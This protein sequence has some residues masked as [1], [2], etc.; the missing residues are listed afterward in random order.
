MPVTVPTQTEFDALKQQVD[1]LDPTNQEARISALEQKV[2]ALETEQVADDEQ[3]AA[4]RL[5][6]EALAAKDD[7]IT[8]E[9]TE[10][11]AR[12][13]ALE[14][15]QPPEPPV[16]S[17]R[18][19]KEPAPGAILSGTVPMGGLEVTGSNIA[20]VVFLLGSQ[21]V[22]GPDTSAPWQGGF[23]TWPYPNGAYQIHADITGT[24]NAVERISVSVAIDNE[25]AVTPMAVSNGVHRGHGSTAP[26]RVNDFE[27]W[28]GG[29]VQTA[30]IFTGQP[31]DWGLIEGASWNL[32]PF[33]TWMQAKPG[34]TMHY[35]LAMMPKGIGVTLAHL[36]AGQHDAHFVTAANRLAS[37]GMLGIS[38]A[39]G[40]EFDGGWFAWAAPAGSG[41]EASY[42]AAFKRIVTVMRNA[43]PSNKWKFMWNPCCDV[44][45]LSSAPAYFE[46][47][48]PGD[49]YADIIGIDTYD[50]SFLTSKVYYPSGTSR[51]Q[52]QQEVWATLLKRLNLL[53]DFARKHGKMMAFPEWGCIKFQGDSKWIGYGG[54]D[55][56]YFIEQMRKFMQDPANKFFMHGYFDV[57]NSHEGDY[58]VGPTSVFPN[59]QA[60]YKALFRS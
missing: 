17:D 43:Q 10:I 58:R 28:L 22:S 46:N 19:F 5:A 57:S 8:Q 30:V 24:D 54:E 21:Q 25:E 50:K 2:A 51:A 31:T 49:A 27:N 29:P 11:E 7:A 26:Q 53:G 6:L 13:K 47:A 40:H 4:Q 35:R 15:D 38:I 14:E 60:K 56:P 48:W 37:Y 23:N 9:L 3:D 45:P 39:L 34:R 33:K 55:N 52:R 42:A 20:R 18:A 44:W 59:A 16:T 36:A 41:K 1:G 32:S 12:V